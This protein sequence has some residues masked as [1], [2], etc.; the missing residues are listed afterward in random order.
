MVG[1]T[2]G[3]EVKLGVGLKVKVGVMSGHICMYMERLKLFV[4]KLR[5]AGRFAKSPP[6]MSPSP[7]LGD[8]LI[9]PVL[10]EPLALHIKSE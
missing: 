6:E 2:V 5:F 4:V 8:P 10:I 3:V 7:K 1:V 9:S